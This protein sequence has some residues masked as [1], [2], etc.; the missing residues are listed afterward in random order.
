MVRKPLNQLLVLQAALEYLRQPGDI[1]LSEDEPKDY[2]PKGFHVGPREGHYFLPGERETG[3]KQVDVV[4]APEATVQDNPGD[5]TKKEFNRK[6]VWHHTSS[7]NAEKIKQEGM[8][9]GVF[10]IGGRRGGY[11]GDVTVFARRSDVEALDSSVESFGQGQ[12][13]YPKGTYSPTKEWETPLSAD[14]L[15]FVPRTEKD[16]HAFLSGGSPGSTYEMPQYDISFDTYLDSDKD[17]DAHL[18]R[19]EDYS[20]EDWEKA[21]GRYRQFIDEDDN[22]VLMVATSRSGRE[23]IGAKDEEDLEEKKKAFVWNQ[24]FYNVKKNEDG[25]IV[26]SYN[27]PRT[28]EPPSWVT[29]TD[30]ALPDIPTDTL[31]I[32][33]VPG[34]SQNRNY[35]YALQ[36]NIG[37]KA[38]DLIKEA[39]NVS[40]VVTRVFTPSVLKKLQLIDEVPEGGD[41]DFRATQFGQSSKTLRTINDREQLGIARQLRKATQ[42]S[43]DRRNLP[44]KFYVYRGGA[45]HKGL[46]TRGKEEQ[47]RIANTPQELLDIIPTSVS[48]DVNLA[49]APEY[50]GT[51]PDY[52]KEG[53]GEEE[54]VLTMYEVSRDDVLLDMPALFHGQVEQELIVLPQNLKNPRQVVLPK[55]PKYYPAE[56]GEDR[57]RIQEEQAKKEGGWGR[58]LAGGIQKADLSK[59]LTLETTLELMLKA[60]SSEEQRDYDP[61]GFHVGPRKGRYFTPGERETGGKQVE[62]VQA[63]EAEPEEDKW[64]KWRAKTENFVQRLLDPESGEGFFGN[65]KT[66]QVSVPW[67]DANRQNSPNGHIKQTRISGKRVQL[68]L[69][70]LNKLY[71]SKNR[72]T[73]GLPMPVARRGVRESYGWDGDLF[74]GDARQKWTLDVLPNGSGMIDLWDG[75]RQE[76]AEGIQEQEKE[77][78]VEQ[79]KDDDPL[80]E[81]FGGES[82]Q[83]LIHEKFQEEIASGRPPAP[84][85]MAEIAAEL[86]KKQTKPVPKELADRFGALREY[87]DIEKSVD[88]SKLLTLETALELL[89]HKRD[90]SQ[91]FLFQ[92]SI[93]NVVKVGDVDI[94]VE[95]ALDPVK[96]LSGRESMNPGTGM[97]FSMPNACNFWMKDMKFP[98]DIIWI[99]DKQEVVDISENLPVPTSSFMPLYSPRRFAVYALEINGGEAKALGLNIGDAVEIDVS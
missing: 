48:F 67:M 90:E 74:G 47:E 93:D 52:Y 18:L 10:G 9:K 12:A 31:H 19:K 91:G 23:F 76:E 5:L 21:I 95:L 96:G 42:K 29:D 73:T 61:K 63:P 6:Y 62:V 49:A 87:F 55:I 86:R 84:N 69:D 54:A 28:G 75:S 46:L 4:Q 70:N 60:T 56:L 94:P 25:F 80:T 33:D 81:Y 38:G 59:L 50:T 40:G 45:I 44:E 58:A 36:V 77:R 8:K 53:V 79:A 71:N 37:G 35:R 24:Y 57:L 99:N 16:P 78:A 2:D 97:L 68:L 34:W 64:A 17:R 39:D 14:K 1:R 41:F 83:A 92:K 11:P 89:V 15:F 27:P 98:L 51:A 7:E 20:D 3:G 72:K 13:L 30:N 26:N 82:F 85:F 65:F 32:D 66:K 43:L 22:L 88:L